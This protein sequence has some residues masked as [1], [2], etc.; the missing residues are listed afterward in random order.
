MEI[1]GLPFDSITAMDFEFRAPPGE[2]PN[3]ICLVAKELA[4]GITKHYWEEDLRA[5][6]EAPFPTGPKALSVAYYASAELGCFLALGWDFPLN[7]L[8]LFTEF[9]CLTNRKPCSKAGLLDVLNALGIDGIGHAEKENMRDLAQRGGPWTEQEKRDLLEYCESDVVAL[10]KVLPKM[11][12]Y[13]DLPRALLR[14]KYMGAAAHMEW[15]GIPINAALLKEIEENWLSIQENLI[16]RID[17]T[18]RV[19]DRN[20][21]KLDR[22]GRYLVENKI[23]WPRLPSGRLDLKDE[24]FR[25]M[26]LTYPQLAGLHALRS[27]LAQM[28]SGKLPVGSDN[29]NRTILSAFKSLTGRNQPST[30]NFIF[31]R[32][33]S[34]T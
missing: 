7:M 30:N 16:S 21:F 27:S 34:Y 5:L 26:S 12:P 4:T 14:G 8:D 29:R 11:L 31:T 25:D 15:N 1:D 17:S 3:P 33:S 32:P 13:I 20:T 28:R 19:F 22:F 23:P 9:R 2:R 10:Q 6:T 18:Y 24:T